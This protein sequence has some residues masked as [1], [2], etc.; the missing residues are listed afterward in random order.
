MTEAKNGNSL[1]PVAIIGMAGRFPGANST[2]EFWRNLCD[3]I[4]S[5]STF[6]DSELELPDSDRA[7]LADP[8]YVKR[9]AILDGI[10]LFDAAF[11]GYTAREAELSDPQQRFFLQC[12]HEA[13]E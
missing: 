10:E 6:A 2:E 5:I 11:F 9:Q 13:L 3:G 7:L 4:E 12:A 8:H 1:P